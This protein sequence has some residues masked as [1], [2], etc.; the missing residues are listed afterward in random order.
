MILKVMHN[1]SRDLPS[2]L[3]YTTKKSI[4]LFSCGDGIQRIYG[5][6]KLKLGKVRNVFIPETASDHFGGFPGFY[7]SRWE[8]NPELKANDEKMS[9]YG[10]S[11][12]DT[13]ITETRYFMGHFSQLKIHK[14]GNEDYDYDSQFVKRARGIRHVKTTDFMQNEE[15]KVDIFQNF[16]YF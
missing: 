3:A 9:V 2:S 4:Y 10:P 14:Y 1:N 13:L 6:L 16:R 11:D 15:L 7:N 5:Q 12:F 8:F